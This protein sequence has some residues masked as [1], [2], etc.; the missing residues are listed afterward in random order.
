MRSLAPK[1]SGRDYAQHLRQIGR[2]EVS[3]EGDVFVHKI[4]PGLRYFFQKHHHLNISKTYVIP[5]DP[6]VPE[7]IRGFNLGKRV[8]NIGTRGDFVRNNAEYLRIC[9]A[10]EGRRRRRGSCGG[11]RTGYFPTRSW[12]P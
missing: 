5:D 3:V 8:D 10:W 12:P 9:R 11:R 6:G 1:T 2:E 7:A 4:L